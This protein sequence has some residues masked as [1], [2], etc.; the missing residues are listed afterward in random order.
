MALSV[1]L[2]RSFGVGEIARKL[3]GNKA[4]PMLSVYPS[5]CTTVT[6]WNSR[7]LMMSLTRDGGIDLV[8]GMVDIPRFIADPCRIQY[9]HFVEVKCVVE[10]PMCE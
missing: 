6:D 5:D 10:T 7:Q 8:L 3:T 9:L 2:V 4:N 1:C